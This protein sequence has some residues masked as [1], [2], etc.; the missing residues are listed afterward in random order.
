MEREVFRAQRF[1]TL[2]GMHDDI[3]SMTEHLRA[4]RAME[5]SQLQEL[6]DQVKAEEEARQM[7][8]ISPDYS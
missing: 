8:P 3:Y 4:H 7:R 2:P 1:A 5:G 6:W